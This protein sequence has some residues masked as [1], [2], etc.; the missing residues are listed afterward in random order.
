[1]VLTIPNVVFNSLSRSI[2]KQKR[3]L[4]SQGRAVRK[5]RPA[6]IHTVKQDIEKDVSFAVSKRTPSRLGKKLGISTSSVA[7][8]LKFDNL[9]RNLLM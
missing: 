2:R 8:I 9:Y 5:L 1:M 7:R 6:N 3:L 4:T